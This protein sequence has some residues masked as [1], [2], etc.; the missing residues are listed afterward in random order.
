MKEH[1]DKAKEEWPLQNLKVGCGL[2]IDQMLRGIDVA[3][4]RKLPGRGEP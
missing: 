1:A 4:E 3:A 2:P